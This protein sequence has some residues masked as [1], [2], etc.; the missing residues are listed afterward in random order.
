MLVF[1]FIDIQEKRLAPPLLADSSMFGKDPR[2]G[3][4]VSSVNKAFPVESYSL[5][6]KGKVRV[7]LLKRIWKDQKGR[8]A[9]DRAAGHSRC[10][11][12][13]T[14]IPEERNN[15]NKVAK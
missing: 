10:L 15:A 7:T 6:P 14:P 13:P 8:A 9:E 12:T 3:R 1:I 11:C 4:Q 5:K 2:S